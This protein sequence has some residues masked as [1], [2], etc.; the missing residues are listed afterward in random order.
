MRPQD[1]L[2]LAQQKA[3]KYGLDPIFVMAIA[4]QESSWRPTATRYERDFYKS[5]IAPMNIADPVEMVGRATSWGLMQ[6]MGQVARELG[7]TGPFASLCDPDT[8][9]EYGCKNLAKCVKRYPSDIDSAIAAYNAG[10]ARRVK[11]G[12]PFVNQGYVDSV[13]KYMAEF[14]KI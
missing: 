3:K 13:K 4:T 1:I 11:K 8:G 12:G 10:S 2:I 14:R 5:Y 9:L 7:Y 6:V